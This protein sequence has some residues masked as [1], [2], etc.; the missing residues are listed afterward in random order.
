MSKKYDNEK[1]NKNEI[2]KKLEG[3]LYQIK[4]TEEKS[5]GQIVEKEAKNNELVT[6]ITQ[7]RQ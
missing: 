1:N 2:I 4:D 5:Y 7:L 3:E 6:I